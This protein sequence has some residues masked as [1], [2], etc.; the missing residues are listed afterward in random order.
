MAY[1]HFDDSLPDGTKN[2]PATLT[3]LRDNFQAMRD[4]VST[5]IAINWGWTAV[6]GTG[7]DERPQFN[8]W[9]NSGLT[10]EWIQAEIVWGAAG[11]A[12]GNA[13]TIEYKF[14]SDNQVTY[15]LIGKIQITYA[16]TGIPTSS[17]WI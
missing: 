11:G 2:G 5:G 6:V 13:Q 15:D 8:R 14:S 7:T 4:M 10:S 16:V 17:N 12:D 3:D 1:T 9:N